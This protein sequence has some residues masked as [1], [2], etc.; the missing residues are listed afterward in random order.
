[1]KGPSNKYTHTHPHTYTDTHT[2]THTHTHTL[3][4]THTHVYVHTHQ[5]IGAQRDTKTPSHAPGRTQTRHKTDKQSV[6]HK[7]IHARERQRERETHACEQGTGVL[8]SGVE[9]GADFIF[10]LQ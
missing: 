10:P 2:H 3:R 8:W 6:I 9:C 4:Y 5:S 1:M 7:Y